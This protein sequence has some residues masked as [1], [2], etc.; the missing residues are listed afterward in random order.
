MSGSSISV[1][2]MGKSSAQSKSKSSSISLVWA[3][4][5]ANGRRGSVGWAVLKLV[6]YFTVALG[7][8][9]L[10]ERGRMGREGNAVL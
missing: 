6:P 1:G 9:S 2:S 5:G 8:R 3:E 4:S 10:D 7:W